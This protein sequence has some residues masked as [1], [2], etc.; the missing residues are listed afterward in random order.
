MKRY[1]IY[2]T[3]SGKSGMASGSGQNPNHWLGNRRRCLRNV[4]PR[5]YCRQRLHKD[6]G[7]APEAKLRKTQNAE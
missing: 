5:Q 4:Y 7:R 1:Q 2:Q 3:L 6:V